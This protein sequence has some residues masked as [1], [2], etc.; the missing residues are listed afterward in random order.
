MLYKLFWDDFSG[1]VPRNDKAGLR[2]ADRPRRRSEATSGFFDDLLRLLHPFMPF[3][4]EEIWQDLAPRARQASRSWSHAHAR[5]PTGRSTRRCWRRFELVEGGRITAVRN[6]R[7]QKNL[8]QKEALTLRGDRRRE[9]SGG[10]RTRADRRWPTSSAIETGGGEGCLRP[11]AF[12]VKTTQYFVPMGGQDR[13][14]KPRSQQTRQTNWTYLRGI[15][16]QA[17]ERKLSNERFVAVGSRR[18]SWPTSAPSRPT[19]KP[20]SPRSANSWRR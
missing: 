6:V 13:H 2:S 3:V 17:C 18:R 4:T 19:P 11:S 20:R 1:L 8:P 7:K 14:A 9:L 16:R 15:P 10:I 12:I 5:K